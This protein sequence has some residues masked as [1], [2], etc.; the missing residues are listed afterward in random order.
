MVLPHSAAILFPQVGVSTYVTDTHVTLLGGG[1]AGW[2]QAAPS[3]LQL[4]Q[5]LVHGRHS[6]CET[7]TTE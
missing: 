5:D 7:A 3:L 2:T 6:S 1:F 4:G